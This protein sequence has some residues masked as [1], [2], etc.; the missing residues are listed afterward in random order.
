M[1]AAHQLDENNSKRPHVSSCRVVEDLVVLD[2]LR[3]D[4]RHRALVR[5]RRGQ[6][7]GHAKV[8]Q[9]DRGQVVR[10]GK[11]LRLDVAVGDALAVAV[12][13]SRQHLAHKVLGNLRGEGHAVETVILVILGLDEVEQV[14]APSEL[15]QEDDV[16]PG[17]S[18]P[19]E[20]D[21]VTVPQTPQDLDLVRDALDQ[22]EA[23]EPLLAYGLHRP[24]LPLAVADQ[25][26]VAEGATVH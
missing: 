14:L 18:R 6:L 11:V 15:Q 19:V 13:Q 7:A 10:D 5:Q 2:H 21:D 1:E 23:V 22:V 25:V 3:S 20:A 26:D 24:E 4:E 17:L 8:D 16:F 12:G 9:L